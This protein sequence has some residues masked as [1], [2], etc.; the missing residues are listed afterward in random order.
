[1]YQKKYFDLV[2]AVKDDNFFL[3]Y[4]KERVEKLVEYVNSIE[5][6]EMQLP[7]L[8]FKYEAEK[9]QE[10]VMRLDFNRRS[11]HNVAIDACN[12]LNRLCEKNGLEL[13]FTCDMDDRNEVA[14][15]IADMVT[16]FLKDGLVKKDKAGTH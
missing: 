2:E 7:I 6:M 5:L 3:N 13:L 15:A 10:E 11:K 4:I 16:E 9:Y 1:M 8:R 14:E 12:Q